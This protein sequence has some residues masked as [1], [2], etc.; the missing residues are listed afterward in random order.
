MWR[1]LEVTLVEMLG[2]EMLVHFRTQVT[3]VLSDDLRE[4][5]DDPEAYEALEREAKE[6]GQTFVARFEPGSPPKIGDSITVG[7]RTDKLH[8]FDPD[9][10]QA[11]R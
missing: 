11:L 3:P 6:G 2:A 4:A 7:F 10:G 8:F 5:I 9:T 1:D